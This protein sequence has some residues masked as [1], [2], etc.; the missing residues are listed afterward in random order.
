M[1]P[2][3]TWFLPLRPHRRQRVEAEAAPHPLQ[4]RV[5]QLKPVAREARPH[6][7]HFQLNLQCSHGRRKNPVP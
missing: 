7:E 2:R 5:V 1:E 6:R 4:A 3:R